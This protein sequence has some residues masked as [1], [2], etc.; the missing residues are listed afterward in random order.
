LRLDPAR[1]AALTVNRGGPVPES[2]TAAA[3][4]A[5]L[6]RASAVYRRRMY[7]FFRDNCHCF[8]AQLMNEVRGLCA[9]GLE[10]GS[11]RLEPSYEHSVAVWTLKQVFCGPPDDNTVLGCVR[12]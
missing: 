11:R 1:A 6:D 5:A 3:W 8:V 7:D 4:D 12:S 2:L 10:R 9:P